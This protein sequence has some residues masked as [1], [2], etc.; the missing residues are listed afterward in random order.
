MAKADLLANNALLVDF[1]LPCALGLQESVPRVRYGSFM[2]I[3]VAG[4]PN[5]FGSKT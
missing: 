1:R 2:V 5:S 4:R 3:E